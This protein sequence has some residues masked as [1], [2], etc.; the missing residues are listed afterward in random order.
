MKFND[1]LLAQVDYWVTSD[2]HFW[3]K[4]I[5]D[6]CPK[7]RPFSS[8]HQMHDAIVEDWNSKVK[9][10]DIVF[11]LGDFSFGN[12]EQTLAILARLNGKIIFIDGNHDKVFEQLPLLER[13][14]MLE[15]RLDGTKVVMCHYAMR[16]WNQQH[17]GSVML[18]GHSHGGMPE[19]GRSTDVGWDS[20]GSVQNLRTVVKQLLKREIY[21]EDFH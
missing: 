3:H 19:R 6:F 2:L 1:K 7:T 18:Y 8:L 20:K 15:V 17:R 11:H 16:A 13:H 12:R 14:K 9:P 4:R 10:G 21:T 5:M